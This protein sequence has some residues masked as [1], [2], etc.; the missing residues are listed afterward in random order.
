MSVTDSAKQVL[1][2]IRERRKSSAAMRIVMKECTTPS[3]KLEGRG[4]TATTASSS[5]RL[6]SHQ[7]QQPPFENTN[8]L[9]A[10][11]FR[12]R[13]QQRKVNNNNDRLAE[14][15]QR[16]SIGGN[17]NGKYIKSSKRYDD[18]VQG[19]QLYQGKL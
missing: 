6:V 8:T 1:A 7:Q 13:L 17:T 4:A 14:S 5:S 3:P 12:S 15:I 11:D 16:R 2:C 10:S 9:I 19:Q 18:I